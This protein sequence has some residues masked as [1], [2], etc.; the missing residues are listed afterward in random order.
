MVAYR[1]STNTVIGVMGMAIDFEIAVPN[2]FEMD[3]NIL[4]WP[5]CSFV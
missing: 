3:F 5:K 2:P 1:Q 4:S